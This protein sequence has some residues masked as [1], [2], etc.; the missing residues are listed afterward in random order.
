MAGIC[1]ALHIDNR[2]DAFCHLASV[3]SFLAEALSASASLKHTTLSH[4]A[5]DGLA[6]LCNMLCL[7]SE[8]C[9][10]TNLK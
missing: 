3:L 8:E 5:L 4:D 9:A 6:Q 1:T 7:I 2:T 10:D